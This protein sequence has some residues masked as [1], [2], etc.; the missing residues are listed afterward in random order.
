[1]QSYNSPSQGALSQDYWMV[2]KD[3]NKRNAKQPRVSAINT[4]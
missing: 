3:V 1:M 4:L 2:A